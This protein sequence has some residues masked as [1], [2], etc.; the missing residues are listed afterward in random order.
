MTTHQAVKFLDRTTPPHLVTLVLLAGVSAMSMSIFLPSLP[1]MT[2]EFGTSYGVMQLSVSLYLAFTAFAQILVG[3]ISDKYGRRPIV[4][5][6]L[7]VFTLA[8]LGCAFAQN[9]EVFLFFR[10][11]QAVVAV[12]MALSRAI[13][14]DMV[15]QAESAAMIG[16]VTMGMSLVPMVAPSIGG[17]LDAGFGWR[18]TFIVMAVFGFALMTLSFHDQGET[19]QTQG[20]S[21]AAQLADYPEL[22]TSRRFWGYVLC[23][24]FSSGAFFAFLG[25]AP[26]VATT[27]YG[28]PAAAVGMFLG[29]PAIG[30]FFGNFLSGRLSVRLGINRMIWAGSLVL[31]AG[32]VCS[33]AL[34]SFGYGSVTSFFIFCAF[35]GLGN[36]MVLPNATAGLLSVRPHLAGT[37]SGVGSAIMIGGGAALAAVAGAALEGSP[38]SLPLQWIMTLSAFA[39]VIAIYYVTRREAQI[40]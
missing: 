9:A 38:T 6:A 33:V 15:P 14:R 2:A 37:A 7:A 5:G 18:T 20:Q 39:C 8:S 11:L 13:V 23:A 34:T 27:V 28:Q 10:M 26:Y 12:T 32:M 25:G 19:N 24:A 30:Y 21:F 40:A 36:G 22:F 16:Y 35:V 4:L 31:L 3:P 29:V 17:L 1:A